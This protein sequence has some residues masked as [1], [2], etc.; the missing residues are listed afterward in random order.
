MKSARFMVTVLLLGV[1]VAGSGC[2][3]LWPWGET[4]KIDVNV[5][6]GTAGLPELGTPGSAAGGGAGEDWVGAGGKMPGRE[7]DIIAA[8]ESRLSG[9]VVY[10]AFDSS[11]VGDSEKPKIEALAKYLQENSGYSVLVEGHCD[12]RGSDE[13]NRGLGERRALAVRDYL[14]SL[15]VQDSRIETLS[16]GE[17]RPVIPNATTEMEH[18]KNR[19]AEFVVGVRKAAAPAVPQ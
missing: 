14:I 6:G 7:S 10:F 5:P 12:D 4:P 11:A 9:I 17:E 8:G 2:S 3:S 19:R 13:Y 16:F 18:A 1:M 15:S